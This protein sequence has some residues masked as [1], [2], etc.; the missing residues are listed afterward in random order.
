M[1]RKSHSI[2][3]GGENEAE[4]IIE[5]RERGMSKVVGL[6]AGEISDN[7]SVLS[8]GGSFYERKERGRSEG[9]CSDKLQ[10]RRGTNVL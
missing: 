1:P 2:A 3:S 4:N 7:L 8:V 6:T 5:R 10:R 9:N